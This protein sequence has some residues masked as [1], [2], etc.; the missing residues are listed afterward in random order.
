MGWGQ[1]FCQAARCRKHI[2]PLART[3]A[4]FYERPG[5]LKGAPRANIKAMK[6]IGAAM[7]RTGIL[8]VE[9]VPW[10]SPNLS[11]K[12]RVIAK[13]SKHALFMSYRSALEN[14]IR[15]C[16][17]VL[18]WSAGLPALRAGAGVEFK[19]TAMGLD[20]ASANI[21][22]IARTERGISQALLWSKDLS[23]TKGIFVTQGSANLPADDPHGSGVSRYDTIARTLRI[24]H[25]SLPDER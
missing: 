16:P 12:E 10:H 20:L 24:Q 7:G 19:A 4:R 11:D 18:S 23:R 2:V 1:E 14:L 9:M 13:L 22:E 17:L 15:A 6:R 5:T 3:M 8:Q 25:P 21:L